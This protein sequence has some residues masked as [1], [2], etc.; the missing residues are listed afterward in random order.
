ML[1]VIDKNVVKYNNLVK[2]YLRVVA[3][4]S[5]KNVGNESMLRA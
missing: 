3:K 5:S 2:E 4:I 1:G